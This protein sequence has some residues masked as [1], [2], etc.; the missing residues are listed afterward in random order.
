MLKWVNRFVVRIV[1]PRKYSLTATLAELELSGALSC[2]QWTM[3][4]SVAERYT[5]MATKLSPTRRYRT[6]REKSKTPSRCDAR[7]AQPVTFELTNFRIIG[8][9]IGMRERQETPA[10]PTITDEIEELIGVQE[11]VMETI[12]DHIGKFTVKDFAYKFLA[13]HN[14]TA[15][16]RFTIAPPE[17]EIVVQHLVNNGFRGSAQR[18]PEM[19]YFSLGAH[20]YNLHSIAQDPLKVIELC[21]YEGAKRGVAQ[22][23]G[24][25]V[26]GAARVRLDDGTPSLPSLWVACSGSDTAPG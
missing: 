18:T 3:A 26:H 4:S 6:V 17:L 16:H 2:G 15:G 5:S 13:N 22:G 8:S 12:Q 20:L 19:L 7:P 25:V 24:I 10:D 9:S 21:F 11:D 23:N 14:I 1:E